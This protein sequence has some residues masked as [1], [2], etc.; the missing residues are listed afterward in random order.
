MVEKDGD[1]QRAHAG[2]RL[3]GV[4]GGSDHVFPER[5]GCI[6]IGRVQVNVPRGHAAS[7]RRRRLSV[8]GNGGDHKCGESAERDHGWTLC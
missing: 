6:G 3:V 5:D 2:Q 8:R 7:P 4:S 1:A